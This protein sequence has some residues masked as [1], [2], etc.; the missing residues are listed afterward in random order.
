LISEYKFPTHSAE[1]SFSRLLPFDKTEWT[2][3]ELELLE[4]FATGFFTHTLQIFPIP[5]FNDR[6]D[7]ILIMFWRAEFD[8]VGLLRIWENTDTLQSILHFNDLYFHGFNEHNRSK[9]FSS[10]G[11]KELSII[12]TNWIEN[13]KTKGIFEER[14]EKVI[15]GN[16]DIDEQTLNELNLLYEIVRT[17]KKNAL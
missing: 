8:I 14:V 6:I 17:E 11:D 7:T 5:S 3:N 9:L 1:L 4:N 15:L 13:E 16:F 2:E 10:F 12:L